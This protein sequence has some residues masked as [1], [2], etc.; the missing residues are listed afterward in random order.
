MQRVTQESVSLIEASS[1]I[2]D[3][4]WSLL[5]TGRLVYMSSTGRRKVT[6]FT[7]ALKYQ[8]NRDYN[9]KNTVGSESTPQLSGS[10][11]FL[12]TYSCREHLLGTRSSSPEVELLHVLSC[13][14][15]SGSSLLQ[16]EVVHRRSR[17]GPRSLS[18]T[19][20]RLQFAE[21]LRTVMM[22]V[23]VK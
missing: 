3:P 23:S 2:L 13:R 18:L 9:Y 6:V 10:D 4:F 12:C 7:L 11:L 15:I 19:P 1:V 8:T 20:A 22:V 5:R 17:S 16:P 21:Y 14:W